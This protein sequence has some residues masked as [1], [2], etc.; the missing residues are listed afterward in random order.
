LATLTEP[1]TESGQT[2]AFD[3]RPDG[4]SDIYSIRADG[5]AP[6]RL[7]DNPAADSVACFS[8]DGRW[9]FYH[10]SRSG[11]GHLYRIPAGGGEP[12]QMTQGNGGD[13]HASPDGKW[14]YFGRE[15]SLWKVAVE[16]GP[17]TEV[18]PRRSLYSAKSF[19]LATSG[20]YFAGPLDRDSRVVP[21]RLLRYGEGKAAE[22]TR[23]ERPP[24]LEFSVSPDEKW[25]VFT[26]LD[27]AVNEV[28][29]VENFQ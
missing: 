13:P 18:L 14:I 21:L 17:E 22:V 4:Q 20:I 12:V 26:R 3:A 2:I 29:L 6:K 10:S 15:D 7:T 28:M 11:E 9:V 25:L 5:G 19:A 16:G 1:L 8:A 24:W 23:F 27:S